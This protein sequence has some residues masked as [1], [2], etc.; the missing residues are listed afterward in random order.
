MVY[1]AEA[2]LDKGVHFGKMFVL[3]LASRQPCLEAILLL[4]R[5]I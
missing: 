5:H 3:S 2:R 4:D 1:R